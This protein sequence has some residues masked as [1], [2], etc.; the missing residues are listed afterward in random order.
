MAFTSAVNSNAS[1]FYPDA[2][3]LVHR[4][5]GVDWSYSGDPTNGSLTIVKDATVTGGTETNGLILNG[6]ITG[7]TTIYSVDITSGGPGFLPQVFAVSTGSLAVILSAGGTG[8]TGKLNTPN[9]SVRGI[10]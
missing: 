3:T 9:Y 7:G 1:V 8:I 5:S 10:I 2:E 4:L 6:S